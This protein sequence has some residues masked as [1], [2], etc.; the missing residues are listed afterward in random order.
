MWVTDVI[1]GHVMVGYQWFVPDGIFREKG[2]RLATFRGYD[3]GGDK[4]GEG[5]FLFWN[6]EFMDYWG[7]EGDISH[8]PAILDTK[9][10]RGGP[11]MANTN[12]YGGSIFAYSDSRKPVIGRIGIF[13]GRTESGG[14]IVGVDPSIEWKPS[15]GVNIR[16]SPS[17]FHDV[18]IA[19]WVDKVDDPAASHTFGSRYIFGRLDQKELSASIRIN[20]TFTPKLSLQ[21]Y[22]QPLISVGRY[23]EFKELARPGTYTFNSY[24]EAGSTTKEQ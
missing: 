5:Y 21:L 17:F 6:V 10:T 24:G 12:G 14:Y 8:F 19:H 9:N 1:N 18:T 4:I 3:F 13:S 7:L 11:S 23:T 22:V 20:W 15:S 2:I 16:F